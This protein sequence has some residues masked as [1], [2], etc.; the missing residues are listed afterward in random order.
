MDVRGL[1]VIAGGHAVSEA[2]LRGRINLWSKK[3]K[4]IEFLAGHC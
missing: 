4:L 2:G 1:L 3:D